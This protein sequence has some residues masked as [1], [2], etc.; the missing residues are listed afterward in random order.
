M[1]ERTRPTHEQSP[2]GGGS[3]LF[4]DDEEQTRHLVTVAS[5]PY[6]ERLPVSNM[7][8]REV[9][10]RFSDRFDIDP[11]SVAVL[12]GHDVND[13]T[14][15]RAGQVLMFMHRAG[16]K[17]ARLDTPTRARAVPACST[18]L[19]R[20]ALEHSRALLNH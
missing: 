16:E 5:G 19:C 4:D 1:N 6:A 12:D 3:G 9:R 13:A 7:S 10:A 11:R 20:G 18:S 17:G 2:G 14:V 8:V 15:V